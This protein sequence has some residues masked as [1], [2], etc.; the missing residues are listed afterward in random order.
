M[1]SL[2]GAVGAAS[3]GEV[4]GLRTF[5]FVPV[6]LCEG[7]SWPVPDGERRCPNCRGI[8]LFQLV[9]RRVGRAFAQEP[10]MLARVVLLRIFLLVAL[11]IW[12]HIRRFE[13]FPSL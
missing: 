11:S 7:C 6:R 12:E 1:S 2:Q 5:G 9:A 8:A 13:D 10:N 3:L 4:E